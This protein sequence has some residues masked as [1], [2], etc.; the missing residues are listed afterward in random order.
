MP[1]EGVK[2][3]VVAN[4]SSSPEKRVRNTLIF[5][6]MPLIEKDYLVHRGLHKTYGFFSKIF[7]Q[8]TNIGENWLVIE[9]IKKSSNKFNFK[10]KPKRFF[11]PLNNFQV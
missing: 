10:L 9:Y 6:G 4:F 11:P 5:L 7:H 2:G 3:T 8:R 1:C